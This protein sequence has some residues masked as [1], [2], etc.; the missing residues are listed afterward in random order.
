[1]KAAIR[2]KGRRSAMNNKYIK[3]FRVLYTLFAVILLACL[4]LFA[5]GIVQ[6]EEQPQAGR[7]STPESPYA[8]TVTGLPSE[9]L[10]H[11]AEQPIDGTAPTLKAHAHIDR[12]DMDFYTKDKEVTSDPRIAWVL[13]LQIVSTG[14]AAAVV[15]LTALLLVRL[16]RSAKRGQVFPGRNASLMT[17]TGVL[18]VA[19]SLCAD[20]GTYLERTLA[21]DLLAGTLWQPQAHFTIHFTLI[22]FGLTIIFLSQVFRMGRELQE[23]QE[24]TV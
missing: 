4:G 24:L 23:E 8:F 21:R 1:M 6:S 19:G 16:Y 3:Q 2:P 14:S 9:G 7:L 10:L 18:M 17:A 5:A 15:V 11:N 12:F 13:V 22:F 20:T